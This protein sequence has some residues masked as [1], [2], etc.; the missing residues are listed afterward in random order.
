MPGPYGCRWGVRRK[1]NNSTTPPP[2]KLD[3]AREAA[4]F[5]GLRVLLTGVRRLAWRDAREGF[6]GLTP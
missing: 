4:V 2:G 5:G 1:D 3:K 6:H